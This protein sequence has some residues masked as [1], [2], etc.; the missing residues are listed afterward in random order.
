MTRYFKVR[1]NTREIELFHKLWTFP[2]RW[3]EIKPKIDELLGCDSHD[4][5]AMNVTEL[6]MTNPPDHLREQ[7]SKRP[8][9]QG[10]YRAKSKSKIEQQWIQFVK[11]NGLTEYSSSRLVWDLNIPSNHGNAIGTLYPVM[12]GDYYFKLREGREWGEYDWAVE[13]DEP[14][15]LRIRADWLEAEN[16]Q[17]A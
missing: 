2:I 14:T 6:Y 10:F 16:K 17:T 8:D 7:F 1:E 9:K 12:N 4:N 15:F 11:I 3:N 5:V 13:V